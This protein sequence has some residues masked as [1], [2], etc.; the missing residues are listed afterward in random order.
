MLSTTFCMDASMDGVGRGGTYARGRPAAGVVSRRVGVVVEEEEE[1][2]EEMRCVARRWRRRRSRSVM[3]PA[4]KV[5]CCE[6]T[7]S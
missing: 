4:M 7:A 3:E 1:A 5:L 2:A 6:D